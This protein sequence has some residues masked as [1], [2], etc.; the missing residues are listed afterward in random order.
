[1]TR[2]VPSRTT[3]VVAAVVLGA[4]GVVLLPAPPAMADG[5]PSA[6]LNVQAEVSTTMVQDGAAVMWTAPASSGSSDVTSY[7]VIPFDQESGVGLGGSVV[8]GSPPPTATTVSG[9]VAGDSYTFTVTATNGQGT[10]V[11]SAASDAVVPVGVLPTQSADASSPGSDGSATTSLGPAGTAS[12]ITATAGGGAGTVAVATYPSEPIGSSSVQGRFFDLSVLTGAAFDEVTVTFCGV[13]VAGTVMWWD[14]NLRSYVSASTQSAPTGT[15][16]CVTLV[17]TSSTTPSLTDLVGTVFVV[18]SAP[19]GAGYEVAAADGGVFALGDATFLGSLPAAGAH[20]RNVVGMAA[21]PDGGGYWLV[22]ADGGVFAFGDARFHGSMAATRLGAPV[23]GMAVTPDGGGY[24]LAAADGGVFALG[25]AAFFG[26]LPAADAHVRNVVG[27]AATPDGGGY[28]LVGADG[29][30][31][32]FGDARFHGSMAATRLGAP[33]VGMA[34]TPDG[35]GY[36]LAAADGG[37]FA[38]G[39]AAFFGSLPAAGAH[40]RNVVGM[41]ATPDGGGYWLVGADGGVFAFGDARFH[42]SLAGTR[43]NGPVVGATAP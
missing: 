31:F 33:V 22:G 34:V 14:P 37:V 3:A 32:A 27:M 15:G 8:S 12:S 4:A 16:R 17:I 21:T 24:W 11:A 6:P 42:G 1:M 28:W 2:G 18:P 23:V 25:D 13:A 9:L 7:T 5:V 40:V 30:V 41:A 43:L 35:G 20:V 19:A 10:S 38:L 29:G 26:S 36:W 39:D